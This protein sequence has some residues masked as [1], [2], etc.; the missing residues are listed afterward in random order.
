MTFFKRKALVWASGIFGRQGKCLDILFIE[1]VS[2]HKHSFK[3]RYCTRSYPLLYLPSKN[4]YPVWQTCNSP[5]N[6]F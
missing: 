6:L 4:S 2:A 5:K 3:Q 1:A